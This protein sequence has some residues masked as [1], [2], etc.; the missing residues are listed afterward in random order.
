MK[1]ATV[2]LWGNY[3]YNI[4]L[5]ENDSVKDIAMKIALEVH[6]KEHKTKFTG[7][8][9][10]FNYIYECLLRKSCFNF[11][12]NVENT[13]NNEKE[14]LKA[15]NDLNSRA[16]FVKVVCPPCNKCNFHG[17]IYEKQEYRLGYTQSNTLIIDIDGKDKNNLITVKNFYEGVLNCK[18]KA[19]GTKNG[20]WL[21]S[22]K[23]YS[24]IDDW[25]YDHCKVLNPTLKKTSVDIYKYKLLALD[26][27]DK[28]GHFDRATPEKIK[29]SDC[30]TVPKNLSFDVAFTFLSIKRQRSTIRITKKSKD[31]KIEEVFI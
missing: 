1:K 28:N 18:F 24:N 21:F 29:S 15:A 4:F 5:N 11:R 22:N 6:D 9:R 27:F 8:P 16:E 26:T 23:K 25:I 31:D 3:K 17:F 10:A 30:Y 7:V 12:A 20:Y 13:V 14:L 19:I 2:T